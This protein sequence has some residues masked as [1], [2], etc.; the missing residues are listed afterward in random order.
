[1]PPQPS[2]SKPSPSQHLNIS[3]IPNTALPFT[4]QA[5]LPVSFRFVVPFSVGLSLVLL[6]SNFFDGVYLDFIVTVG[7]L[8]VCCCLVESLFGL[9]FGGLQLRW[10]FSFWSGSEW[11][12]C[13]IWGMEACSSFRRVGNSGF[14]WSFSI[15]R[16]QLWHSGVE[17]FCMG[18]V[19]RVGP[20]WEGGF[21]NFS[22]LWKREVLSVFY[23]QDFFFTFPCWKEP[24]VSRVFVIAVSTFK[25]FAGGFWGGGSESFPPHCFTYFLSCAQTF[26]VPKLL[27]VGN[28]CR[29]LL[30]CTQF[31]V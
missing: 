16:L 13:L 3:P 24:G 9:I 5:V 19:T 1:M 20:S 28:M 25:M 21:Y 6:L 12:G 11:G 7:M 31:Q 23:F 17:G 18:F 2:H 30:S 15:R 4:S 29:P 10:K 14:R 27:A 22:Y 8:G 26:V